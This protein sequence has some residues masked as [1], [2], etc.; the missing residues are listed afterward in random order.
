[1]EKKGEKTEKEGGE[2]G[3]RR[4]QGTK[5][6]KK[7]GGAIGEGE[8]EEKNLFLGKICSEIIPWGKKYVLWETLY[9]PFRF[10]K[11]MP[12]RKGGGNDK[13]GK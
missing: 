10:G 3:E 13:F 4:K 2:R 5:E 7:E 6:G 11:K 9:S 1:M 8:V 12:P